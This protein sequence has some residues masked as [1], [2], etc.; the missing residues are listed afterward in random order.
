MSA[1]T[2]V[3]AL[4]PGHGQAIDPLAVVFGHVKMSVLDAGLSAGS[5]DTALAGG[6]RINGAL[7]DALFEGDADLDVQSHLIA[8]VANDAAYEEAAP[9]HHDRSEYADVGALD[10]GIEDVLNGWM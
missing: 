8:R 9:A 2:T 7:H 3:A 1:I 5:R 10:Q 4:L 6:R